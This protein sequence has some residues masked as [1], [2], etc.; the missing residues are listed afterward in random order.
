VPGELTLTEAAAL[1]LLEIEGERS[2]YDLL[3][4]ATKSIGHVWTPAKSQL[5]ATL[6]RLDRAGLAV[7]RVEP[8][9][10]R[11]DR[12]LFKI[13]A[14]G[15]DALQRWLEHV[16]GSETQ[17]TRLKIFVGGL[18]SRELLVRHVDAYRTD[19]LERLEVYAEIEKTNTRKGHDYFHHLLLRYG[20]AQAET[21]VAWADGVLRELRTGAKAPH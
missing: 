3:K 14:A 5:Y 15:R 17:A 16:D 13:T 12:Q 19:A 11:P 2:G 6:R 20:I 4:L 18:M 10:G 9:T 1:A 7:S 21:T 8:Q